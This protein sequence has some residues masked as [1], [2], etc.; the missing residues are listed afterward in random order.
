MSRY[1]LS[2]LLVLASAGASSAQT[3][4]TRPPQP[5]TTP[6]APRALA[7]NEPTYLKLRNIKLGTEMV[8]VNNFTM[9]REAG[10]FIFKSGAF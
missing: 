8:R 7:N 6:T 5:A 1:I 4:E 10:I 2:I 3:L 9:K